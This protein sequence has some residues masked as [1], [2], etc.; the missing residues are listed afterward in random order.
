MR[1]IGSLR[2]QAQARL[3]GEFLVGRHIRNEVEAEADGEWSVWIRDEDQVA[4]AQEL[5]AR[6]QADPGAPEF[7]RAPDEAARVRQA[8]AEDLQKFRQRIRTR[9]SIFPKIGN[10]GVGVLTYVLIIACVVVTLFCRTL[11]PDQPRNTELMG[12]LFISNPET[13]SHEFLPE[14][15][16]GEVWRLVTPIF[17]HLNAFHILF[18]MMALYHLGCMIEARRGTGLLAA[19]VVVS[20]V[21]SNVAQYYMQQRNHFV[22][23]GG[24]SGVVYALAGYAWICGRY[25]RASS[26]ALDPRTVTSLLVWLVVCYT[27]IIGP[28]ANTAHVVGLIVGM[29][30]GRI[31]AYRA[32]RKPD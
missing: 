25:Y 13:P 10:Y 5:L 8:E 32:L 17:V 2:D 11:L 7:Q 4:A 14:V 30:W 19:L 3:F 31:A 12:Q 15:R 9:R 26:I 28:V 23:F 18:N 24:I 20:A 16:N 21:L 27:G 1:H 29:T 22:G 6:F